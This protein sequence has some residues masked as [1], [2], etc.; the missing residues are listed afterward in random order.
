[1]TL[2][3]IESAL[4][5]RNLAPSMVDEDTAKDLVYQAVETDLAEGLA[6]LKKFQSFNWSVIQAQEERCLHCELPDIAARKQ[7]IRLAAYHPLRRYVEERMGLLIALHNFRPTSND[8]G[9]S[10]RIVVE[11]VQRQAFGGLHTSKGNLRTSPEQTWQV[12]S[13]GATAKAP[14]LLN[15]QQASEAIWHYAES[16]L[17]DGLAHLRK[18][19]EAEHADEGL[20][21]EGALIPQLLQLVG[22]P[23]VQA[24]VTEKLGHSFQFYNCCKTTPRA[25]QGDADLRGTVSFRLQLMNQASSELMDC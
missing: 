9:P 12:M 25:R 15:R 14:P 20:N 19:L 22:V 17:A 24:V 6:Y 2:P 8:G 10:A 3:S 16:E 18:S 4:K 13:W 23:G 11:P 1:M 5:A 21:G 7:V